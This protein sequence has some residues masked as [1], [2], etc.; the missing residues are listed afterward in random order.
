MHFDLFILVKLIYCLYLFLETRG[1]S[2]KAVP[3]VQKPISSILERIRQ[4]KLE[5]S[6]K[7]V[8]I[9]VCYSLICVT[10][11]CSFTHFICTICRFSQS[12]GNNSDNADDGCVKE[13]VMDHSKSVETEGGDLSESVKE[14]NVI[15]VSNEDLESDDVGMDVPDACTKRKR[16]DDACSQKVSMMDDRIFYSKN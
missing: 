8:L 16:H 2:F 4:R 15:S 3:L 9:L 6:K 1:V 13:D 14:E 10:Y 7:W 5:V 12:N 11:A